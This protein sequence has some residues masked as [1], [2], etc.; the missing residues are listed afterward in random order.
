[1]KPLKGYVLS[2]K[3]CFPTDGYRVGMS[4]KFFS[5]AD[6]KMV[7]G[8][9]KEVQWDVLIIKCIDKIERIVLPRYILPW[10]QPVS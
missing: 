3:P 8:E 1:M 4:V 10:I 9:I 6:Q 5:H 7:Y 2:C